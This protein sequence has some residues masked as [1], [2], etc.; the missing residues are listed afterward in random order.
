M[1]SDAAIPPDLPKQKLSP[2]PAEDSE[3][4]LQHDLAQRH[5]AEAM[6][7]QCRDQALQA[8]R[9]L[10]RTRHH[11]AVE[12]RPERDPVLAETTDQIVDM[13]HYRVERR[14]FIET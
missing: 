1:L 6:A 14:V 9:V 12:V 4:V 5:L 13:A 8:A 10:D 3:P 7:A 2:R 11:R